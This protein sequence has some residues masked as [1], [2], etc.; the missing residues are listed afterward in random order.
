[1]T[2]RAIRRYRS[3]F[4]STRIALASGKGADDLV[5]VPASRRDAAAMQARTEHV[6]GAPFF[7][8]A[9]ADNL[10]ASFYSN[11]HNSPQL[12][13]LARSVQNFT[14]AGQPDG[15]VIQATLDAQCNSTTNAI[16]L[17]TLLDGA[18]IIG[19]VALADPKARGQMTK[20]QAAFLS[21]LLSDAKVSHQEN[22]VRL[23]IAITPEM[24]GEAPAVAP[25]H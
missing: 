20:E 15:E 1:M 12:E 16:E 6:A 24:L 5:D 14:L 22:W 18:R 17:A 13:S 4:S 9:R 8:V 25:A 10:P 2:F 7:A 21:A 23:D 19:S 11:F 3:S